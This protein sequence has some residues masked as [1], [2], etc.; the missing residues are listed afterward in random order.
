MFSCLQLKSSHGINIISVQLRDFSSLPH[1]IFH[2][3]CSADIFNQKLLSPLFISWALVHRRNI[4]KPDGNIV[5]KSLFTVSD[6]VACCCRI[7]AD[8]NEDNSVAIISEWLN[9]VRDDYNNVDLLVDESEIGEAYHPVDSVTVGPHLTMH[10]T[11]VLM[12]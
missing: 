2:F 11:N 10:W 3:L 8:H 9:H 1:L 6:F 12:Q 5:W 4:V 7:R